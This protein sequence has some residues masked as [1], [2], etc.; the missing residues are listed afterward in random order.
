MPG[1]SDSGISNEF[2]SIY[3]FLIDLE[4]RKKL[5]N[6]E[7]MKK[8]LKSKIKII[9]EMT[10]KMKNF[11]KIEVFIKKSVKNLSIN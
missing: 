5:F 6:L 9:I 2:Q 1:K 8:K 4:K 11:R 3:Q 10:I 7:R